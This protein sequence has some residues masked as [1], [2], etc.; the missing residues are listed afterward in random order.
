MGQQ[1]IDV[2]DEQTFQSIEGQEKSGNVM[3]SELSI[4]LGHQR[5]FT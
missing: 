4:Y 3:C 5:S 1:N 2:I